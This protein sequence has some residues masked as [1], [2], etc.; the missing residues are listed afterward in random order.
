MCK[1]CKQYETFDELPQDLKDKFKYN[2]TNQS[3]ISRAKRCY[4]DFINLLNKNGDELVGIYTGNHNKTK[5]KWKECGHVTEISKANYGQGKRCGICAKKRRAQSKIENAI[6]E[7]GSFAELY[8]NLVQYF[9]NQDE[10]YK[11][12]PNSN[13]KVLIRCGECGKE[14]L[15][16]VQQLTKH[17]SLC[18]SCV[19]KGEK[20]PFYGKHH[21]EETKKRISNSEK[22]MYEQ[23][24][25]SPQKGVIRTEQQKQ[26]I[27]E[28]L[29]GR[30]RG[31]LSSQWKGGITPI[32]HY[33]R[34]FIGNWLN[35]CKHQANYTCQLTGQIGGKLHTHHLYSFNFIVLDAHIINNIEIK[36]QIKDYTKEELTLLENYVI[37][38]HQDNSNA[39]VLC[40]EIH[41]LF[42]H[43]YGQGDNTP[44][45]FEE[46]K[47]RYLN[48]EFNKDNTEVT[49]ETKVS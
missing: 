33:L 49:Q 10:A 41:R 35:Q 11:Y 27:R 39:V 31:E 18:K 38:W 30:Y 48:G 2:G 14:R 29:I 47:Q 37:S 36:S 24:Y 1:E 7:K 34:G 46:F 44:E 20:N 42:H 9:V 22:K 5:I 19:A 23:G 28:T 3:A 12:L 45:Q 25:I 43:L 8:P 4:V 32:K 15:I 40:E 26:K 13:K 16:P 6:L 17:G 21:T